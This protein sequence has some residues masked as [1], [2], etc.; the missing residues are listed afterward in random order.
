MNNVLGGLKPAEVFRYFEILSGIPRGSGHE[1]KVSDWFVTFAKEQ[2]LECYQDPKYYNILIKKPGTSG[3]ENSPSVILHGHM[4]M[5]CK[6]EIGVVHDFLNNGLE[7]I[8]EDGYIRAKGTT[9]GADNG[10]GI[11]YFL[12]VLDSDSIPHPPLEMA[13]TIMEEMGKVGGDNYQTEMLTGKRMIDLNWH[14]DDY[15]LAGCAGDV[16]V[17][18]DVPVLWEK[19]ADNDSFYKLSIYGLLGGHCE[20]DI[21]LERANAIKLAARFV[22]RLLHEADIWVASISGGVQNNVIPAEAE[23]VFSFAKDNYETVKRAVDEV[24]AQIKFEY[25]MTDPGIVVEL[26]ELKGHMPYVFS[27]KTSCILSKSILL[28]PD[29]VVN[30]SFRIPEISECSNNIGLMVTENNTVKIISTITS[31]VASRKHGVMNQIIALSELVGNG[32]KAY[33]IGTD[34]PEWNYNPDSYMLNMAK[35]AYKTAAGEEAKIEIMPA[36]LELGLF[37]SRIDGLDIISIGTETH[38]V[39]TPKEELKVDSVAKVW[40]IFK[41]LLKSLKW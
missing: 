8:I 25:E 20:F 10:I 27:K 7:L 18:Y 23:V 38:G 26:S 15:I 31:S 35:K 1:K 32:V 5:V 11:A 37:K 30:M 12:A 41:E 24:T 36:S 17:Q 16:S 39:H 21:V 6:S 29:G 33:Q 19:A 40:E 22:E 13:L 14:K 3:Y 28:I 2:G 4:D 34:A 9:L